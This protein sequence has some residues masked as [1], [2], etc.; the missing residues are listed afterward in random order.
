MFK[1][2]VPNQLWLEATNT[3]TYILN[4]CPIKSNNMIPKE[5]FSS[6]KFDVHRRECL[7]LKFMFTSLKKEG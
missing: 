4:R 3:S 2:R 7:D 1:N 5:L 6:L